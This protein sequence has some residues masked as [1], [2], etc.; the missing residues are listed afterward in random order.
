[1]IHRQPALFIPHGGGP[2]FFM[3]GERKA[4]FESNEFFLRDLHT[5][6][7]QMPTAILLVTAHWET[8]VPSFTGA[9]RPELIYDYYGFPEHTY[10]LTYP[11]PGQ[12]ASLRHC[13]ARSANSGWPGAGYV[14]E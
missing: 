9:P 8:D 13:L 10:S 3:T 6:L 11:A 14:R 7:P 2:S 1:M 12:P 4:I 5:Q